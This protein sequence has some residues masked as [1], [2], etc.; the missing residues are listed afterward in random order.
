[1]HWAGPTSPATRT[2]FRLSK[3]GV[4]AD[5]AVEGAVRDKVKRLVSRFPIYQY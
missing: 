3:K 5:A 1:L 4:D 2:A